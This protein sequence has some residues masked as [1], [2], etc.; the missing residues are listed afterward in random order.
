MRNKLSSAFAGF[1]TVLAGPALAQGIPTTE[2]FDSSLR[3]CAAGQ[4]ISLNSDLLGSISSIYNGQRTQGALSFSNSTEFLKLIPEAYRFEAYRL[5]VQC[6]SN[7]LSRPQATTVAP[8]PVTVSFRVCSGEYE[9]A[10]QAH[11]SYLYCYS[12]VNAWAA[13]K[14]TSFTVTRLNTYGATNAV[15]PLTK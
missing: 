14:C 5:Y 15:I 13:S 3:T 12:D 10:C 11:D 9:R 4:S 6:I 8:T 1:V 7:I 2:Q